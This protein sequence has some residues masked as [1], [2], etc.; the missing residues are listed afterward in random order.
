MGKNP[1]IVDPEEKRL[2]LEWT[3][4]DGQVRKFWLLVKRQLSVGEHRR[5]M[6]QVSTVTQKVSRARDQAQEDPTAKL[7]WTEYSF[8][9]MEAYI[10][11]WSL[12]H[13]PDSKLAATRPSYDK[14]H[15]SLFDII[16]A[17]L[18][19]HEQESADEKK[20]PSTRPGP[21]AISA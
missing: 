9:R 5:M 6:R 18:D 14:L 21:S 8:A 10:T 2:E 12:A 15:R 20:V 17:A 7:E 1:W 4:P 13:E 16:D 19:E 3:D 11:D